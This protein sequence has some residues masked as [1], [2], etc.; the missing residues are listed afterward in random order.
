MLTIN[1][2][3]L[4]YYLNRVCVAPSSHSFSSEYHGVCFG[5]NW[6]QL[7]C[8]LCLMRV[9]VKTWQRGRNEIKPRLKQQMFHAHHEC[10]W[11]ALNTSAWDWSES[12]R[13]LAVFS[14][15]I[16]RRW[17]VFWCLAGHTHL[18]QCTRKGSGLASVSFATVCVSHAAVFSSLSSVS[19]DSFSCRSFSLSSPGAPCFCLCSFL[20]LSTAIVSSGL[21]FSQESLCD[22]TKQLLLLRGLYV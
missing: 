6:S 9:N 10:D 18:P 16:H 19:G 11:T 17:D 13:V 3:Y 21:G 8:L 7:V 2:Y 15:V 20:C 5:R 12:E 14:P 1:I 22:D 4:K